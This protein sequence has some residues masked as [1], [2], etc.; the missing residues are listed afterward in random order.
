MYMFSNASGHTWYTLFTQPTDKTEF[1]L[2]TLRNEFTDRSDP[3]EVMEKTPKIQNIPAKQNTLQHENA[4]TMLATELE[5]STDSRKR[6]QCRD[7][8]FI[9]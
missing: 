6:D 4:E 3:I 9:G 2:M 1:T 8:P 7:L 5:L